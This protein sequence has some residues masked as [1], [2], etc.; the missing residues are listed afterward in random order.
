M[1][2][3]NFERLCKVNNA[4]PADVCKGTGISSATLSSWKKGNYTP[5]QDK[6]HLIADFFDVSIDELMGT[7]L[8]NYPDD[9]VEMVRNIRDDVKLSKALT[10]YFNLSDAKKKHIVELI[11]LLSDV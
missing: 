3:E 8:N 11:N 2:Y 7:D 4:K 10:Q 5:K 6:L 1:Y 9:I